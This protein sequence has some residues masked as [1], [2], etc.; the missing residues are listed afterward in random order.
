M[1]TCEDCGK[2][3]PLGAFRPKTSNKDG[4]E[5]RCK[6]CRNTRYNKADP[7]KVFRKIYERQTHHSIGRG[8]PPPAYSLEQLIAWAD[9]QP[10]LWQLWQDYVASGYQ[11]NLKPSCDRKDNTRPYELA[12]LEI[13]TW[14]ENRFRACRDK[15]AG[16]LN[17]QQRPVAAFNPD[18]SLH[19][20]YV[21]IMDAVRDVQGHMWGVA[22]VANG[23]PVKGG[24]GKI[25]IPKTYKGFIWKWA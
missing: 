20:E 10:Q 5:I 16:I 12:N 7:H 4:L 9:Q 13:V 24:R 2:T 1:K 22:S 14:A 3:L 21:S 17:A 23:K 15:R 19:K 11:S 25:Y 6:A 18:G 8:H